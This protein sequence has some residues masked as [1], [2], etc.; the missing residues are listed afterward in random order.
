MTDWTLRVG[1]ER[2]G[3]R[4]LVRTRSDLAAVRRP[5]LDTCVQV[6]LP[7]ASGGFPTPEEEQALE[8]VTRA[9]TDALGT[10]GVVAAHATTP[11]LRRLFAYVAGSTDAQDRLEA[12]LQRHG[13]DAARS[14]AARRDPAWATLRTFA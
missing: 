2:S 10:D 9:V 13:L 3:G 7:V 6:G 8:Q 4:V 1:R 5:T 11:G 12:A 14:T